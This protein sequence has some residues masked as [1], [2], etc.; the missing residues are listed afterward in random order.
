MKGIVLP[1][2]IAG[3]LGVATPVLAGPQVE[4][5]GRASVAA[6]DPAVQVLEVARLLRSNDLAGL[7]QATLP[8]SAYEKLRADYEVQR[9]QPTTDAQRA[10]FAEEFARFNAPDA[11]DKLMAEIEPKLVEARPKLPAALMMGLGAAQMAVLSEE[12]DLTADQR[13]S[14]QQALPGLQQWLTTTDF[15]SSDSARRALTV[16][17]EAVRGSGIE[18]I[19]ELKQMSFEQVLAKADPV[20]AAG[21]KAMQVYGLDVNAIVDSIRVEVLSIEGSNA[22]VR[23]TVTVFNAPVSSEHDLVLLD[24]R[25]YG[26]HVLEHD[27]DEDEDSAQ[28]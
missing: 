16:L 9:K 13:A 2:L 7:I 25:W 6:P 4:N 24:G 22:R 20:L 26:R 15:L 3:L 14:L 11:I 5:A 28:G 17:A 12:S 18:S 10:K 21:K 23:T 19:D 1:L 8:P 27:A